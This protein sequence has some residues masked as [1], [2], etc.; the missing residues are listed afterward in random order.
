MRCINDSYKKYC[1]N[2]VD[3]LIWHNGSI[4]IEQ[5][6]RILEPYLNHDGYP[7]VCIYNKLT[8]QT[9]SPTVHRLVALAW[10]PNDDLSKTE[11]NHKDFNRGNYQISNLEWCTRQYNI[12]YSRSHNR[13]TKYYGCKNP[14]YGNDILSKKYR[15]DKY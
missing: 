8:K 11:V 7:V 15:N 1:F 5:E 9:R 12:A 10:I 4:E 13:Y 14:N 6:G 3:L 2:G